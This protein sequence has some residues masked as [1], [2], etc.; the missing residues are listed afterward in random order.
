MRKEE[1]G[2]AEVYDIA[3]IGS[4]PA[5]LSAALTA[6]ARNLNVIWFGSKNV[7]KKVEL[8]EKISNYP[9]LIEVTG[10]EMQ[11]TFKRQIEEEGLVIT[12]KVINQIFPMGQQYALFSGQESWMAKTILIAM[13]MAPNTT[14]AG[15]AEYLGKGVSYCA[16]C[17]GRLYAGKTIAVYCTN[18]E[19][20]AEVEFLADIAEKVYV[21]ATYPD[22][23]I[24]RENVIRL[25]AAPIEVLGDG[26]VNG[27]RCKGGWKADSLEAAGEKTLEQSSAQNPASG[28]D[29]LAVDGIFCLK[30]S[31]SPVALIKGL[32][33]EENHIRVNRRQETNIRGCYAAGDCTGRPYQYAKAVGEGNVAVH[34][35]MEYL[36]EIKK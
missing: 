8:A 17:D 29:I 27:V 18:P 6:K 22:F 13:G 32:E 5:G 36:R 28:S 20:E 4:G 10:K 1:S 30:D 31:Y 11:Q 21:Y 9:G 35:I 2:M 23:G 12:E 33:Q 19:Y 25:A 34:S 16:T 7:S 14:M 3:I 26:L 24:K 15:E